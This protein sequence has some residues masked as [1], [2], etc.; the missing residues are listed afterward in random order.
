MVWSWFDHGFTT[1]WPRCCHVLLLCIMALPRLSCLWHGLT[2]VVWFHHDVTR[3]WIWSVVL[4]FF[5]QSNWDKLQE[6]V[7]LCVPRGQTRRAQNVGFQGRLTESKEFQ[8]TGIG[9]KTN[10]WFLVFS[11]TSRMLWLKGLKM[12][13][14][15]LDQITRGSLE[16]LD[17]E[18]FRS[19]EKYGSLSSS[20]SFQWGRILYPPFFQDGYLIER[21]TQVFLAKLCQA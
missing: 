14:N 4:Q 3:F 2:I 9:K 8:D 18:W 15:G 16:S 20:P 21:R 13:G 10:H 11:L 17:I 7:W 19:S 6:K 12:L 5:M 1:M